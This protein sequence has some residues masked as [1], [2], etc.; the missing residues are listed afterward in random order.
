VSDRRAL[1]GEITLA[2]R[3]V[4]V[5]IGPGLRE[6]R[7]ELTIDGSS[8]V[9]LTVF[10]PDRKL[11]R[12]RLLDVDGKG[13]LE[14]DVKL[15]VDRVVYLLAHVA[16]N[17][18]DLE[19]TFEDQTVARMRTARRRMRVNPQTLGVRGFIAR[20]CRL[21]G[22]PEPITNDPG[23]LERA[24]RARAG[25]G[26]TILRV[27]Q[28]RDE[29]D[30]RRRPGL[31]RRPPRSANLT[32][33]GQPITPSQLE[34]ADRLL[35]VAEQMG[36][37]PKATIA[38]IE[39]AI[40]E[41]ELSNPATPSADGYGSYGVLQA[42]VGVSRGARGTIRTIAEARDIEYM[43]ESFLVDKPG[44]GFASKGGAMWLERRHP[45]WTPG[46]IAQRV[47]MSAY[48]DRYD[49][50]EAEARRIIELRSGVAGLTS[51]LS[52][53]YTTVRE[54]T[55][56]VERGET[57]WD[58]A[59][60]TAEAYGMRFF[61][62]ANQPYFIADEALMRSRPRATL[63]E[64]SPG[65]DWIDWEWAPRKVVRITRLQCRA[66]MWQLPVG[67]VVLLDDDC[68]PARGRWLVKSFER[69]RFSPQATVEL[70][71]GLL[72][73]RVP[74]ERE[75][76]DADLPDIPD[77][78]G[79]KG[80]GRIR[81]PFGGRFPVTSGYGWRSGPPARFHRGIDV[82]M[83][84][85]T[86]FFAAFDGTI[87]MATTSGFGREG[88]MIH[89]RADRDV[90][91]TSI[92]AGDKIGYGHAGSVRVGVGA[93]VKAGQR[94]GASG[95]PSAPHCHFVL[96]RH[97]GGGNGVDGNA[98]PTQVCRQLGGIA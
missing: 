2:G 29:A 49:R 94:I 53:T 19:L 58:A 96:L 56:V 39:A 10:D 36:A 76:V 18:D 93:K 64:D 32:V 4:D 63:S 8:I 77:V 81:S 97:D 25:I 51:G 80:S 21:A 55:L 7:E 42:R 57:L 34:I 90:P 52:A 9:R 15:V 35:A 72:R 60:R 41:S 83:P 75:T 86:P 33:K 65:I 95:Y 13:R 22:V 87:T 38:L 70:C 73:P 12:S 50:Y 3:R 43:A 5:I 27:R 30:E 47:E 59:R 37:G 40:V 24:A 44:Y 26:K 61:V 89:L 71:R 74:T 1:D 67:V 68:G 54:A 6:L 62:V 66:A 46:Q 28:A 84:V 14:R 23:P 20:L 82:A 11:A 16:K 45:S 85:G 78:L 69:S 91:G 48:P 98:D 92:R 31:P 88:G 79:G 17:G